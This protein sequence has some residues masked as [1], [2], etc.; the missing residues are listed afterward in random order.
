MERERGGGVVCV[1]GKYGP[2]VRTEACLYRGLVS[3]RMNK[4]NNF[5]AVSLC[6]SLCPASTPSS[7]LLPRLLGV[8]TT[9]QLNEVILI[10]VF[11]L[12]HGC[13]Q[14]I[15]EKASDPGS[16]CYDCRDTAKNN[17]KSKV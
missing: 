7:P 2:A 12:G 5:L 10:V 6:H 17:V 13:T 4:Y 16:L 3:K 15:E 8:G 9:L 1:W 11:A 14:V